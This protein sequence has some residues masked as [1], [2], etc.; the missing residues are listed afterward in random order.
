MK[1]VNNFLKMELFYYKILSIKIG[2]KNEEEELILISKIQANISVS[3]K[4]KMGK[5]YFMMIIAIGKE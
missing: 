4:K 3:M 5:K 2:L 1:L